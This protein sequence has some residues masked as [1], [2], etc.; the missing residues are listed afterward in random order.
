MKKV[1][2]AAWKTW[3]DTKLDPKSISDLLFP[4]YE[5]V[6]EQVETVYSKALAASVTRAE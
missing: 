5:D 6:L 2:Y 1:T 4:V 3:L